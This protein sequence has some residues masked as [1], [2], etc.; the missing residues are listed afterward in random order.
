[1]TDRSD[2]L[3]N[4]LELPRALRELDGDSLQRVANE[5]RSEIIE[6][7]SRN[8]GHLGSSLGA[9]EI[10]VAL[11]AELDCPRDAIIWDVGHQ[12]YAHKLL[13]GRLGSFGSIRTYGGLSGFPCRDESCFDPYGT[14]HA[15]TAVSAA[16]GLVEGRLRRAGGA[17]GRREA[18]KMVSGVRTRTRPGGW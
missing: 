9:V 8:G 10:A 16:V 12:A 13:T 17:S 7:I 14:G 4:T 6:T 18:G 11:H 5:V 15:S 1:V 2:R 3:I